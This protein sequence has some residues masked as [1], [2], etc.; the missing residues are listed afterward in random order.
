MTGSL[1]FLVIAGVS[2][3][4]LPRRWAALPLLLAAAYTTREPI[5][6][7]GPASLSVLRVLVVIGIARV[8]VRG[9]RIATGIV[10][11]D[12]L[13]VAWAVLLVVMSAFH[14]SNAWTLR[15]GMVWGDIGTYLLLRVFIQDLT[16]VKRLFGAFTVALAPLALLMLYEKYAQHNPFAIMGGSGL[17]NIR[18]GH[19]RAYGPFAHSILA[20]TVG[21]ACFP[22]A[23]YVWRQNRFVALL[24]LAATLGIVYASTSSGPIMMV[25]FALA[26]LWLWNVRSRLRLVR[27]GSVA[28]I[29]GLQIV[30]QDPVYFLMARVDITGGSQGWYRAQL[31]RSSLQHINEW[32]LAGTDYTRHWMPSGIPANANNTDITNHLLAMGVLGGLPLLILFVAV[33]ASAFRAVGRAVRAHEGQRDTQFLSWTLGAILFAHVMN[34]WAISLFDQSVVFLYLIFAAIAAALP[35]QSA[36]AIARERRPM[37]GRNSPR[38]TERSAGKSPSMAIKS[39]SARV[40]H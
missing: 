14:S 40:G 30:M 25:G 5:V 24:G 34:F 4:A 32:W 35:P 13:I 10:T 3:V 6:D 29:C 26:A 39:R 37:V 7:L 23:L 22:M 12:R 18:E 15:L 20:G 27:W 36:P 31:I 33:L 1:V 21:A 19:V 28:M 17:A 8:L 2:L 16:D 9:E 38:E 11:L